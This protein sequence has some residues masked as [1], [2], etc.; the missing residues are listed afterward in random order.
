MHRPAPLTRLKRAP[1]APTSKRATGTRVLSS[2][3]PVTLIKR[4][5]MRVLALAALSVVVFTGAS[6]E[7]NAGK[8][9][10]RLRRLDPGALVGGE[11]IVGTRPGRQ[12]AGVHG[13]P[14]FIAALGDGSTIHGASKNDQLGAG[15]HARD[16]KIIAPARGHSLIVGGP[17][18]RIVVSG[19]GHNLIYSHAAGA[20][21]V[22]DSPGNEVIADGP[23][24]RIVC[25]KHSS[26]ELIEITRGVKVA[27]S[28]KGHHNQI[29]PA[30][31]APLSARSSRARAHSSAVVTGDGSSAY[32]FTAD[33]DDPSRVDC[34]VSSFAPRTLTGFWANEHVPAYQCPAPDHRFLLNQKYAPAGT[35]LPNG[36]EVEGL[37]PIGVSI[38]GVA[39]ERLSNGEA[40]NT[41]TATGDT[42]SSATNW[43]F[44]TNSYRVILHCTSDPAHGYGIV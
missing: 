26:H 16:V 19:R 36:V 10:E 24:D 32:P 21:I 14:N 38:S 7:A 18:A 40:R 30:P 41:A 13:R 17:D 28:C 8:L 34:T 3:L 37:G 44:D 35:S 15:P 1:A 12:L 27:K 20:T 11:S 23:H 4:A 42:A 33:C 25:A 43:E 6:A 9:A 31:A 39:Y 2:S 29:E 22:L 5:S